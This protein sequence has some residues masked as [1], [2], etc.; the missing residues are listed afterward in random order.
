MSNHL[1]G[2]VARDDCA[3]VRIRRR[4]VYR[5]LAAFSASCFIGALATD[6]AYWRTADMMWSDFSDWLLTFG[7]VVGCVAVVVAVVETLIL[8][9]PLRGR[10]TWPYALGSL[11]A[12]IIAT[13]DMFVHTRDAWTSV[14][15]WGL[16][17]S[18]ATVLV[19]IL[20]AWMSRQTY[21][22]VDSEVIA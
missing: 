4:P 8:R 22:V 10:M 11:I 15:P 17:L 7:V 18:A 5:A 2:S 20:T 13:F 6:I 3:T 19:L 14:V 12:L 1:S 9:S 21:D 16:V